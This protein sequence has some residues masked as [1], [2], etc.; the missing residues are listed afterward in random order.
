MH[1]LK[2]IDF[3]QVNQI[4]KISNLNKYRVHQYTYNPD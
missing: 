2:V 3:S 1:S 4:E